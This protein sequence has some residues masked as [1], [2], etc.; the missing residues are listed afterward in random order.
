MGSFDEADGRRRDPRRVFL[1]AI[2]RSSRQ[3]YGRGSRARQMENGWRLEGNVEGSGD[4][5]HPAVWGGMPMG[6]RTGTFTAGIRSAISG[7]DRE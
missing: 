6:F 2:P 1:P 7:L 3:V 5:V 4:R